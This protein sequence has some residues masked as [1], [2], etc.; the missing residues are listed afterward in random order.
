MIDYGLEAADNAC[1]QKR[2]NCGIVDEETYL[3]KLQKQIKA[4][5]KID[6]NPATKHEK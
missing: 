2:A 4:H 5:S 6:F 3:G 1:I